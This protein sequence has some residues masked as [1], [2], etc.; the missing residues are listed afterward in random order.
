MAETTGSVTNV[1]VNAQAQTGGDFALVLIDDANAPGVTE[2]FFVWFSPTDRF[3]PT[4][5]QWMQRAMQVSLLREA[6]TSGKTVTIFHDDTSPYIRS[7]Q[8][9]A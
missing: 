6:L 2:V 1:K 5:P 7:V 9:N 8:I 4:G 3:V